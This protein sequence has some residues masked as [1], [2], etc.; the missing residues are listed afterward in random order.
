MSRRGNNILQSLDWW[1]IGLYLIFVLLG[2]CIIY[3]A[4]F[5]AEQMGDSLF[6]LEAR[7]QLLWIGISF[8]VG[9]FL[10]ATD[11][12][13]YN[14]LAY[15]LYAGIILILLITP[16]L[17]RNV[18]GS[19]SWIQIGGFSLQP[20]EF[21]KCIVALATAKYMGRYEYQLKGWKDLIVPLCLIGLPIA[22]IMVWQR[23]TGSALVFFAFLLA[24]YREGMSGYI[25]WIGALAIAFFVIAI[26]CSVI[27]LPLGIGNVGILVCML[28][29]TLITLFFLAKE[30]KQLIKTY[31]IAAAVAVIYAICVGLSFL[32]K[33]NFNYVSIG[34]N[35]LLIGYI[36][37]QTIVWRRY[38]NLLIALFTTLCIG[39]TQACDIVFHKVLQP[40][41]RIRIEVL[42]GLKEDFNGAGFNVQ[43]AQIAMA[44]GQWTGKGFLQGTQ[45]QLRFVPEQHTDFI[46]SAIGEEWGFI[47]TLA[48][49]LL[50]T[51]FIIRLIYIAERQKDTFTRIY[52]Y[53]VASIFFFHLTIN[54]GM[55]IG[56]LPVI[57]IPLPF[58]SYG[59]SSLLGFSILLFIALRLDAARKDKLQ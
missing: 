48:V 14:T 22:I 2:W 40:H 34:V 6:P 25:L 31:Y 26:R 28:L 51:T 58:F 42:L 56:L 9:I 15:L 50:Y 18:K 12:Q 39:Y 37:V 30:Q 29:T 5:D 3:E 1:T 20:A 7:K 32:I 10:L 54:V 46:F 8:I 53:I 16:L 27:A 21:A 36:I 13:L 55:V 57:G 24:F 47:G 43:Q 19:Y 11:D 33:I 38:N 41:Q 44:N 4:S 17:A 59:G 23:E 45:T 49:L 35:A 52:C